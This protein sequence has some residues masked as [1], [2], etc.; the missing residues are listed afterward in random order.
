VAPL[1]FLFAAQKNQRAHELPGF[2][3]RGPHRA[4]CRV[5]G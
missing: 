3:Q 5:R 1:Y 4:F 2:H